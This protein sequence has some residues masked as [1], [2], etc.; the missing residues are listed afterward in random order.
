MNGIKL[1]K[2]QRIEDFERRKNQ[3]EEIYGSE[4]KRTRMY[5]KEML[6]LIFNVQME[7]LKGK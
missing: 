6:N 3:I 5:L 2:K 4:E 1:T 7:I